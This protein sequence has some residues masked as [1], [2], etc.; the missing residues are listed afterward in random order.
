MNSDPEQLADRR[1]RLQRQKLRLNVPL[2]KSKGIT[3][4]MHT[5]A[6]FSLSAPRKN[7]CRFV[8]AY[9]MSKCLDDLSPPFLVIDKAP[10]GYD[11]VQCVDR[12]NLSEM[13]DQALQEHWCVVPVNSADVCFWTKRL[14]A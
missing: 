3:G 12:H 8:V 1:F 14:L 11:S 5:S 10:H 7:F 13:L 4:V 6:V 2:T 9:P